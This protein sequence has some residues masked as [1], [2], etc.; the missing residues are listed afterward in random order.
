MVMFSKGLLP[1]MPLSVWFL[2]LGKDSVAGPLTVPF[3]RSIS[4]IPPRSTLM[5]LS[6]LI[7]KPLGLS[8]TCC[9]LT[10][11]LSPCSSDSR[12]YPNVSSPSP[13][14]ATSF[15]SSWPS[16]AFVQEELLSSLSEEESS[17]VLARLFLWNCPLGGVG[18]G[19]G[20]LSR[21]Y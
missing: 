6:A 17:M 13:S 2:A 10:P 15:A 1:S 11:L 12:R 7:G 18:G 16:A 9:I 4:K 5:V 20:E 19:V 21:S 8:L 3:Q 14:W